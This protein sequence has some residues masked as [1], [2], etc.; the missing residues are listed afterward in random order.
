MSALM[1]E[2]PDEDIEF[3]SMLA[4]EASRLTRYARRLTS[5]MTD[6]ED[7]FQNTVLRCWAARKSFRLGTNF[8]GWTRAV[9]RNSFLS[10][11]RRARFRAELADGDIERLLSVA[12]NQSAAVELRDVDR[13]MTELTP[14]HRTALL[15]AIRGSSIEEAA[16]Q[17][18]IN[19]NTFKSRLSRA[20]AQ[21]TRLVEDRD[22]PLG[23]GTPTK[24]KPLNSAVPRRRNWKGVVIGAVSTS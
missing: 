23:S 13:A 16:A 3:A 1:L 15:L 20:R 21:L 2:R 17:L 5:D 9:M 19:P 12:P 8:S 6:A 24:L 11:R 14:D 10:E 4:E 22:T 7:L 18:S